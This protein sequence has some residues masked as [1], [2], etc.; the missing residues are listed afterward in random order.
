[1]GVSYQQFRSSKLIT[2]INRAKTDLANC[3]FLLEGLSAYWFSAEA[4]A[5]LGQ[6]AL[7]QIEVKLEYLARPDE[8]RQRNPSSGNEP[9]P[10]PPHEAGGREDLHRDWNGIGPTTATQETP[11]PVFEAFAAAP[12]TGAEEGQGE[13]ANIDMLFGD[14]LDLS[15]PTNFWD[16]IFTDDGGST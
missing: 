14:F 10:I 8:G 15:L 16:P 2:H 5:R 1:M 12:S 7:H 9:A 13:F 4:M 3:C 11:D 6:T